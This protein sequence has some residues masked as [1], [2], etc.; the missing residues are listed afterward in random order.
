MNSAYSSDTLLY[1]SLIRICCLET[2]MTEFA[3]NLASL[4][5]NPR[6]NATASHLVASV[7][8]E[9]RT[10]YMSHRVGEEIV[11]TALQDTQKATHL[12]SLFLSPLSYLGTFPTSISR[13][14]PP[15]LTNPP[16]A[17]QGTRDHRWPVRLIILNPL[18][19]QRPK[20]RLS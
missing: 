14:Q 1:Y 7:R 8:R 13:M 20:R 16:L 17:M 19:E 4:A 6:L 11:E 18:P 3:G 10:A 12:L 2:E 15:Q 5:P 9:G